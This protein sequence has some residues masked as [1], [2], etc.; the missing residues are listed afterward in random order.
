MRRAGQLC[1]LVVVAMLAVVPAAHAAPSSPSEAHPRRLLILSLPTL[2]WDDLDTFA[3]PTIS[4]LLDHA[5]IADLS[6]R[7]DRQNA[8]LGAAYVTIGAGT[9]AAGDTQTEGDAFEVNE[10][11]GNATAGDA[12]LQRTGRTAKHGIID[13]G[14]SRIN[15]NNAAL[16]YDAVPGILGD[17]L[18]TKGYDRAVI[19]NADGLQPDLAAQGEPRYD[20]TAVAALMGS[21]GRVPDG[22]VGRDVL[23]ADPVAPFGVR[24]SPTAVEDAFTKSWHDNSVVLV[25]GSDL[26]R[27]ER[28][29][30]FSSP[31]QRDRQRQ[32]A[33]R[34]TDELVARLLSHVDFSRD[35]VLV[36]A[37]VASETDGGLT[38]AG[39][40]S[41]GVEPGL[42]KSATTR[43]AG[44]ITLAD[45]GPTVLNVLG[46]TPPEEMEGRFVKVGREGGSAADRRAFLVTANEDA[47]LRDRLVGPA[48]AAIVWTAVA[49]V[50]ASVF[51]LRR[52]RW[53]GDAIRWIALGLIGFLVATFLSALAHFGVNGGVGLYWLSVVVFA[54]AF[55][56]ICLRLGRNGKVDA[57]LIALGVLLVVVVGDQLTGSHLDFNTVFGYSPTVGIRFSGIGNATFALLG[58]AAI[59]VAALTSWRFA[60]P[61]G[62]RIAIGVLVVSFIA[63]TPPLFGE[64]FGGT[65]AAAPAFLL[66]GWLLLGRRVTVRVVLSMLGV[67]MA[68]GLIVGFLDLLRPANER[69]HVGR[70]FQKVADEGPSGLTTVLQRKGGENAATL[71]SWI[72]LLMIAVVVA[73]LIVLYVRTPRPLAAAVTR[74]PTL[75]AAAASFVVL[76]ALGYALNDS[77]VAVPGTMLAVVAPVV[78]YLVV[79]TEPVDVKVTKKRA[80]PARK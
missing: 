77:G 17:T 43:R 19:A 42:L 28:L 26:L 22:A 33:I 36:V 78:A 31:L 9:R 53:V 21:H 39:L 37:P 5:A 2:T 46:V 63:L 20:R 32:R 44:F 14:I 27:A 3:A 41:P 71:G 61:W 24:L 70:F 4:G 66:L 35:A 51:F 7:G 40:R 48:T 55:A 15:V 30:P 64:D 68:S 67:L 49:L 58:T 80:S 50:A 79:D 13:L 38:V 6:T 52:S 74:I 25:E 34:W 10:R 29:R 45:L 47:L 56:A 54:V 60:S 65:L 76:A 59:G 1:L 8:H 12:Y 11:F 73:A 72:F 18:Q 57:L 69:T 62:T 16:L 23:K 75:R